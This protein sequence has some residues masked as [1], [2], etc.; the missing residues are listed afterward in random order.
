MKTS[1]NSKKKRYK[2]IIFDVDGTLIPNQQD[3]MPSQKIRERIVQASKI[4]H[5]GVATSRCYPLVR[6]I[7]EVLQLS[8]PS[9]LCG[10]SIIMDIQKKKTL[11]K[12]PLVENDIEHVTQT[13]RQLKINY[14]ICDNKIHTADY[15]EVKPNTIYSIFALAVEPDLAKKTIKILSKNPQFVIHEIPDWEKGKVSL[16]IS[17]AQATKQHGILEVAKLLG[18][19]THEIIGVGD[20]YND[21]PL[22]M[23][24]GL[25]IAMGNAVDDLK[26]I[27]DY[28]APPVE[29]DG[30]A[31]ILKK[32]VL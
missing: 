25:K 24:C 23:A 19:E 11:W 9:I 4:I 32:F 2:A 7:T 27:A 14:I 15:K 6:G 8:C 1:S 17:H 26:A 30:V 22:L 3:G 18:I 5:I 21:F 28:I 13:L 29:K 16:N 12:K 10:G 20:G 31:D